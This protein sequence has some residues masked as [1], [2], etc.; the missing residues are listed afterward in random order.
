[1]SLTAIKT[2]YHFDGSDVIIWYFF[3]TNY[4]I[5][6]TTG[7]CKTLSRFIKLKEQL[8]YLFVTCVLPLRVFHYLQS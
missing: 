4:S 6:L 7:N 3:E 5:H 1:M 8:C 2:S